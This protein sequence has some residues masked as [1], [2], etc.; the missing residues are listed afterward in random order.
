M[1][2]KAITID[3]VTIDTNLSYND[4]VARLKRPSITFAFLNMFVLILI[5]TQCFHWA[6]QIHLK[7]VVLCDMDDGSPTKLNDFLS[8]E[9]ENSSKRT[10]T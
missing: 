7:L 10:K 5:E 1:A 2:F 6:T 8:H 9:K 4:D 3:M